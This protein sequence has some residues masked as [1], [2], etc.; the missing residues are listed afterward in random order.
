MKPDRDD[1]TP[2]AAVLADAFFEMAREGSNPDVEEFLAR[3]PAHEAELRPVV[4][5][6]AMFSSEMNRFRVEFPHT[7]LADII[8]VTRT[9]E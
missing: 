1:L 5:A 7:S 2:G 6:A 8:G 9:E 4:E 3:Y